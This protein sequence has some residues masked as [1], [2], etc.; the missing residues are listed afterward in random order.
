MSIQSNIN[1]GIQSALIGL[2]PL[3][4]ECS[5]FEDEKLLENC[6]TVC[7]KADKLC[8]SASCPSFAPRVKVLKEYAQRDGFEHLVSLVEQIPDEALRV[9]AAIISG[10]SVTRKRGYRFGQKV[11]VRYRGTSGSNYLSNFMTAN[12]MYVNEQHIRLMSLDGRCV[13]TFSHAC[14]VN[15]FTPQEFAPLRQKMLNANKL[16]DPDV[17]T[18]LSRRYRAEEEYNLGITSDSLAGNITT[19][20]TVFKE[21]GI[22]RKSSKGNKPATLVDIVAGIASG[23]NM[24]KAAEEYMVPSDSRPKKPK[25]NR[26]PTVYDVSGE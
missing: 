15:I 8:S 9:L 11:Y 12:V 2:K 25:T 10:E 5:G 3:C 6:S 1:K 7:S 17:E 16:L 13:L 22:R 14:K 19:I 4:G 21:N 20:D 26:H 24:K 23:R 18:L